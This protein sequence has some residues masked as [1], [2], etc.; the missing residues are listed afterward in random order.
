MEEDGRSLGQNVLYFALMVG[1]LVFANWG[2]PQVEEGLW[3]TIYHGRWFV[4]GVLSGGLGLVLVAWFG[5][6]WARLMAVALPTIAFAVLFPDNSD[7]SL[8]G[9]HHRALPGDEYERG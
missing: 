5:L 2:R 8:R 1:I 7:P 9:C 3:F 6:S 4:T